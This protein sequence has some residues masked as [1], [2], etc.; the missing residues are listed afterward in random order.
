MKIKNLILTVLAGAFALLTSCTPEEPL[1]NTLDGIELG[2]TYITIARGAASASTTMTIDQAWTSTV[3]EWLT[4]EPGSG[5]AGNYTLNFIAKADTLDKGEVKI[6]FGGKIQKIMVIRDGDKPKPAGVLFEE[7]F[8]GHGQGEFEIKDIVG[9]PWAYDPKYGMKATAYINNANT[10]A[11]SY[12][13]SPELDLTGE[14]VALLTFEDAVNYMNGNAVEDYLSV[15]VTTD[16]GAN[17]EKVTVP[18]WPAGSGWDFV[19]SGD[20]DL[21][22]FVG[23][24]IKFAFHYKSNTAA[25]PTWEIKNVKVSNVAGAVPP[26]LTIAPTVVD[27]S[28]NGGSADVTATT[29]GELAVTGPFTDDACKNEDPAP[30]LTIA[31]AGGTVTLTAEANPGD[32]RSVY[33]LF[34][35]TNANGSTTAVLKVN[36]GAN[37][38]AK[39][40]AITNPY[41]VAEALEIC[42][43]KTYSDSDVYVKGIVNKIDNINLEYGNAQFWISD[44]GTTADLEAYRNFWFNGA[45]Y[46]SEEQ[47]KVG[48]EVIICGKLT[49]YEQDGQAPIPEFSKNNKL[50]SLNG[51]IQYYTVAEALAALKDG[52]APADDKVFVTGIINKIDNINLDYGNAQYWISDDGSS[53]D[54]E[55]YRGL[56][57]GGE[58]FTS[59]DQIAV[60][61]AVTVLG[62]IKI[63]KKDGNPDVYEFD[64]NNYIYFLTHTGG[65]AP[66][67]ITVDG[68]PSDWAAVTGVAWADCPADAELTGIKSA[69]A[70]YGDKLY[71]LVQFSNEALAKGVDDGKLRFHVFFSGAEGLLA[72]FWKDENI[73]YMLEGKATSGGAYT[74]FSSK[75]YKFTGA[76]SADWSWEDTGV[77]PTITSVGDGNFYE[78][79]IDYAD[80]PGGFPEQIEVAVDCADGNYAVLGYAPQTSHKFVL[81]KGEVVELP[82]DPDPGFEGPKTIA[83]IIA[84]IPESATGS[85]TAVEFEAHL[86]APAVVSYV[87]GG[88]AYIQDETGAILLYINN[89]G[90]KAGDTI[91]GKIAA[92]GYWFNG[93]PELVAIGSAYEKGEGEAPAPKEITIA[94]LAANYD[95]NLLR[96]VKITGVTVSDGIADGDRNG[97]ITQGNDKMAVYA[98]LNNK[99]LVLEQGK[100]GDFVTIPGKYKEKQQVYFWDNEWFT[101]ASEPVAVNITIDGNFDDWATV[102]G[103][104]PASVFNA[105]KVWNDAD[106]FYFYVET[107]PGSR[108]WEGGAYLYLYFDW[109]NDLTTGEY[110]GATGMNGNNYE[111]YTYMFIFENNQIGAPTSS[112]VAKSLT[113]DNLQIAGSDSTAEIVKFEISIPRADFAQQVKAG[114]VIGVNAYRSKDGGNVNFPGYVVK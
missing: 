5:A 82:D 100:K 83:Q 114:D 54:F 15:E 95:A 108:L 30:W 92:K 65:P 57:L 99:G 107:D 79:A 12:L 87:N 109:D 28:G 69:K 56:Y 67:G 34:T 25:S 77:V 111:A 55:I 32:A 11:E 47:L 23:K 105:F 22:K 40:A 51:G 102:P 112:S 16:N 10:D 63:Y 62:K 1:I 90:F 35:S 61:D 104:E 13:I 41:T 52:S 68:D 48:D 42:N 36:Q 19:R 38:G 45:K 93:I 43:N 75:L 33:V 88:N 78:M 26:E 9:S 71:L 96:L 20:V 72:R 84:A 59:E 64:S 14:T 106:N 98:Q 4:L 103:A 39:G 76:T 18:T 85:S 80:Y 17:W 101:E 89:H 97:E 58:K 113:L 31:N 3:P 91:K 86:E 2:S 21:S 73:Q 8:I 53:A 50:V 29:D 70:Y 24:K 74:A 6:N 81:K 37:P 60:G 110:S 7:P 27:L 44:D 49:L 94:D 46:T 66:T